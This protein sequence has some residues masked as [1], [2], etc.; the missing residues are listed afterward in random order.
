MVAVGALLRVELFLFFG[1]E[2]LGGL[3]RVGVLD[4]DALGVDE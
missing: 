2:L 4:L 1:G 3:L